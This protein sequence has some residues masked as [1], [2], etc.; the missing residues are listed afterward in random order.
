MKSEQKSPCTLKSLTD[1]AEQLPFNVVLIDRNYNVIDANRQFEEYFGE[2]KGKHCFETFKGQSSPCSDCRAKQVFGDGCVQV[3]DEEGRDRQGQPCHFVVHIAPIRNT[4]GEITHVLRMSTTLATTK[5]WQER[6]NLL[7]DLSLTR[8]I[9]SHGPT[10]SFASRSARRWEN[11]V[12][13]HLKVLILPVRNV[14][15]KKHSMTE[16]CTCHAMSVDMRTVPP[17]I[18]S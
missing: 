13:K 11:H 16:M 3:I 6:Y 12:S 14:R 5:N 10:K 8:I 7:F 4:E 18:M 15:Q 17:P 2:W 9:K 1:L